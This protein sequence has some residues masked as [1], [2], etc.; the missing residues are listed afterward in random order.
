MIV[1]IHGGDVPK[2]VY[3]FNKGVIE[4][5]SLV[6]K[7]NLPSLKLYENLV[8]LEVLDSVNTSERTYTGTI[9]SGLL[10]YALL[11]PLGSIGGMLV[12]GAKNKKDVVIFACGLSPKTTFIAE[13]DK[14]TFSSIKAILNRNLAN[15]KVV[16]E[17]Q[18]Q[19]DKVSNE[20]ECP[21]CAET[22]KLKAKVCRFCGY[23]FSGEEIEAAIEEANEATEKVTA[24][25]EDIQSESIYAEKSAQLLAELHRLAD[26]E[27][28]LS[29]RLSDVPRN[30]RDLVKE[31]ILSKP[32]RET[33]RDILE[34]LWI[35]HKSTIPKAMDC[36]KKAKAYVNPGPIP[37]D[38]FEEMLRKGVI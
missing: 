13:T 16:A 25:I 38:M 31:Y 9:A 4:G 27:Y 23:E 19:I 29:R 18:E 11:G 21:R 1:K 10:G 3:V 8:E 30:C 35:K 7:T 33:T 32:T 15:K 14:E 12:G 22:I 20:K 24:E 36:I 34:E 17:K 28:E 37:D 6:K 2:G 5:P 26:D